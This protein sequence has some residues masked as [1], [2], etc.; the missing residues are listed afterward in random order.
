MATSK[1]IKK[2]CLVWYDEN[3][4]IQRTRFF[5]ETST[6]IIRRL[7]KQFIAIGRKFQILTKASW[8]ENFGAI[9]KPKA[10]PSGYR[11]L[12]FVPPTHEQKLWAREFYKRNPRP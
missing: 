1:P 3:D 9:N 5:K 10:R 4:T 6:E 2:V 7:K 11:D 12:K 8:E